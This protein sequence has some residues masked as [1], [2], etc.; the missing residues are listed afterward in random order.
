MKKVLAAMAVMFLVMVFPLGGMWG[1]LLE[2]IIGGGVEQTFIYPI[3]IG[4][5]LLAGIVVGCTVV[6]LEEIRSLKNDKEE[7]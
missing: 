1:M 5:I 3:Y 6:I 7:K 2:P 4:M